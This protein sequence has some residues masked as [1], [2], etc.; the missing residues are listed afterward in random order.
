MISQRRNTKQGRIRKTFSWLN[1]ISDSSNSE[2]GVFCRRLGSID[3][4][5]EKESKQGTIRKTLSPLK[6][7]IRFINIEIGVFGKRLGSINDHLEKESKQGTI[8]KTF[9]WAKT[10]Y[11]IPQM[12][13]FGQQTKTPRY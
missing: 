11:R 6:V 7:H 8:R 5:P 1:S 3:D 2:I 10:P 4:Q 13:K 9:S 12:Q